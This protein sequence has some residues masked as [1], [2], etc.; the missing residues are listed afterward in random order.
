VIVAV[1]VAGGFA[2]GFINPILGA[3][4]YE[5]IPRPLMGRVT[6]LNTSLCW[7]TIPFGGI[8]GGGLIAA[9][10]L[11]P[12]L[13]VFGGAYFA[14]T[15]LPAVLPQWRQINKPATPVETSQSETT[16]LEPV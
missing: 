1:T 16:E 8:L 6:S 5:R 3:V 9:A 2:S 4:I 10:G 15:M 7:A 11:A 12:A 14:A 13:L